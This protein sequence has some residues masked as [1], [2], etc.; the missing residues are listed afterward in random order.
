MNIQQECPSDAVWLRADYEAGATRSD[1][2]SR[3]TSCRPS[4]RGWCAGGVARFKAGTNNAGRAVSHLQVGL[5]L[6][7]RHT[8]S[9][10]VE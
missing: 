5:S 8:P 4:A 7:I 3:R 6:L 9:N 1:T 2:A 10:E